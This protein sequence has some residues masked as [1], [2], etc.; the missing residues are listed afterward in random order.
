MSPLVPA[1]P[2]T[3]VTWLDLDETQ[4]AVLRHDAVSVTDLPTLFDAGFRALGA[5]IAS[6]AVTPTGPAVAIYHGDPSQVFDIEIGF[7][8]ARP[9]ADPLSTPAGDVTGRVVPA[10]PAAAFSH[11]GPYD[12]L[13]T[14]WE[15]LMTAV[16]AAEVPLRAGGL[17]EVYVTEPTPDVDPATMRTDVIAL[18]DRVAAS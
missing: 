6:G 15:R 17:V 11:L 2:H 10:G 12:T 1:R 14:A 7:P 13:A 18:T 4:V 3:D 5:L 8:I 16:H 9:L